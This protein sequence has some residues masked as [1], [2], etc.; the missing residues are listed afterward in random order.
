MQRL[1]MAAALAA[2][3]LAGVSTTAVQAAD[4][5]RETKFKLI[6][7]TNKAI[8]DE[9]KK[10][11]P[12]MKAIAANAV[13]L[14][15]MAAELPGWFPKGSGPKLGVKTHAL[16]AIWEQPAKFAAAAAG[17]RAATTAMKTASAAGDLAA[18]QAAVP[19]I[20]AS[21]KA[22]HADFKEQD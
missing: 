3:M 16:P 12:D 11:A 15:R 14:D 18:V 5:F 2:L 19:K 9:L 7:R 6:A 1:P 8:N 20:G 22:C 13:K 17:L 4:S 10:P 21:C